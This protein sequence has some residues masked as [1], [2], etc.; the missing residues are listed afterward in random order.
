M[1][2]SGYVSSDQEQF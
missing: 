2:N 1:N